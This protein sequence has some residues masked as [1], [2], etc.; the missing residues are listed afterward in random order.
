MNKFKKIFNVFIVTIIITSIFDIHSGT[1]FAKKKSLGGE[2]NGCIALN[3]HRV[4]SDDWLDKTLSLFSNSKELKIYSVTDTQFESHIKWLKNHDA[5]FLTLKELVKY[6]E[7][8]QYPKR[9]VW[10]NFDDMDESIFHNAHPILKKYNVPATGFVITNEIGQNNFHNI[11]L[12]PKKELIEM[13]KSGL[14]T[15]ASHTHDLHSFK[16]NTSNLVIKAKDGDISTD[17]NNSTAYL[18]KELNGM[19]NALA[20]PYG[21]TN[22]D[23]IK[24]LQKKTDIKYAFTLEEKA[25]QP[26]DDQYVI[27]RVLTSDDAFNKL[28]KKWKGFKHD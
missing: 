4:R 26:D 28:V 2:Q 19:T 15:F 21:Q 22:D 25:M 8:G 13:E 7:K 23:V 16:K 11:K 12:S 9:C 3:Y 18:S 14:W 1:T 27:P 20:Y 6:K 5:N 17:I 24:Q 10:I